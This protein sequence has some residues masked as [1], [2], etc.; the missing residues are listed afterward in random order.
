M[1]RWNSFCLLALLLTLAACATAPATHLG[2]DQPIDRYA[3]DGRF[4]L[5]E[6]GASYQGRVTWQHSPGGD[7]VFV[8]DPFGSGVAELFDQP[9]GARMRL[10]NG[11]LS[12]AADGPTLMR[13]L[14][15]VALP[16]RSVARWLTGRA[17]P[18]GGVTRDLFGRPSRF[19][20]EG[21][22]VSYEYEGDEADLLPSRVF[23][24]NGQGIELRV[25]IDAWTLGVVQ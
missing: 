22:Q 14:T 5:R 9:D 21:W 7:R 10:A 20:A 2:A 12:E 16:V 19:S 25:A 1:A 23:A 17:L 24:A 13:R 8:Q 11:E 6:N 4:G 18:A 3:L 15:G